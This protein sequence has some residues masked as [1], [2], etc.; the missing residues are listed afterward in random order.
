MII[1]SK[2]KSQNLAEQNINGLRARAFPDGALAVKYETGGHAFKCIV[3]KHRRI[4]PIK[5]PFA[6][7]SAVGQDIDSSSLEDALGR[8]PKRLKAY[9]L[10]RQQID[11]TERK[12]APRLVGR[13]LHTAGDCTFVRVD[14]KLTAGGHPGVLRL[15]VGYDDFSAHP[16][17]VIVMSRGSPEFMDIVTERVEDIRDLLESKLLDEACD[18]LCS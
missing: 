16:I 4:R 1:P 12:H 5:M 3:E 14:L 7:A 18:V 6:I 13:K 9:V 8:L 15:E 10:R 17:R 11:D 2:R